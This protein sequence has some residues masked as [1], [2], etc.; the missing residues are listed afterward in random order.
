MKGFEMNK[1][2]IGILC[3]VGLGLSAYAFS[4]SN[5]VQS[6]T[7]NPNVKG[8]IALM[9]GDSSKVIEEKPKQYVAGQTYNGV[10]LTI[11]GTNISQG[12][13]VFVPYRTVDG[14]WRLR[15]S[16]NLGISPGVTSLSVTVNGV[17]GYANG[18]MFSVLG[19]G[20]APYS[21]SG[22]FTSGAFQAYFATSSTT[23]LASGDVELTAK[24]TWAD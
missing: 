14:V 5:I 17:S 9:K 21:G 6:I 22:N 23:M 8:F 7:Y 1:K 4:V 3:A 12:R 20:T 2:I 18:Q 10:A 13:S 15:F 24:P 19:I 11:S 16:I